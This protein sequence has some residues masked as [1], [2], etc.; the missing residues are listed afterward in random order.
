MR[1]YLKHAETQ[2]QELGYKMDGIRVYLGAYPDTKEKGGGYTTM[3]FIP[4]GMKA[5][6]KGSSIPFNF[7]NGGEDIPGGDGLNVGGLGDPPSA[8]YPQ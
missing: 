6:S 3:F 8:S 1:N 4:T 2:T 5:L 7:Q